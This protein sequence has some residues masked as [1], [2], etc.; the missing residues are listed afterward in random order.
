MGEDDAREDEME[1]ALLGTIEARDGDVVQNLGAPKQQALVAL[2][3]LNAKHVVSRERI[4][5]GLWGDQPPDKAK[6][7]VQVYVSQLRRLLPEGALV[8][9]APG[10]VLQVDPNSVDVH[11][12]ER[13]VAKAKRVEPADAASLLR[14][15][16]ALWRGPA[17]GG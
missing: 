11:R 9:R 2:L 12:F 15:A 3:L 16:L 17:L 5:D 4:I 1:F 10:Y 13:L 8:T 7:A 6:K 14:E